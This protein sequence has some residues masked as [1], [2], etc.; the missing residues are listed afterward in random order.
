MHLRFFPENATSIEHAEVILE[1]N[2]TLEDIKAFM[3]Q[4]QC[5]KL[6]VSG[7][8]G[9]DQDKL[10]FDEPADFIEAI[11]I[12]CSKIRDL[13]PLYFLKN[14][15]KICLEGNPDIKG[16]LDLHQFQHLERVDFYDSI[17][18]ITGL[19]DHKNLKAVYIEPKKLKCLSIEEE[20]HT[21]EHFG[22]SNSHI[23]DIA[24]IQKLPALK[25]IELA[26]LPKITNISFLLRC[27]QISEIQI[28]SCKKIENLIETLS[29]LDSLTSITLWN[30]G[31]I[32]T[33]QP[34]FCLSK[35]QIV[36]LWEATKILDGKV[37]FLDQMPDMQHLE[38]K[39]Y[40]HYDK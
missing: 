2:D 39:S 3:N 33:I 1:K 35:L 27:K 16:R 8:F 29:K 26:Y 40:A 7:A 5:F 13:T 19:F 14:I 24:D 22:L 38:I 32:D 34:F 11:T 4:H 10:P 28:C 23:A 36:R 30:Q 21:I 25:S 15:K 17:K 12:Q 20:N 37:S 9:F 31:N 18:N 6:F